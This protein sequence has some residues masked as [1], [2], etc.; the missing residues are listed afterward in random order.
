M[1]R[2]IDFHIHLTQTTFPNATFPTSPPLRRLFK[3]PSVYPFTPLKLQPK[4]HVQ[5]SH[6]RVMLGNLDVGTLLDLEILYG[7]WDTLAN[8]LDGAPIGFV[9]TQPVS[10]CVLERIT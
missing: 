4:A 1:D 7:P 10:Y 9:G 3:G 8:C 5:P 2:K 6:V